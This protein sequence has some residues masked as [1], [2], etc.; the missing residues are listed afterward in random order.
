MNVGLIGLGK[1]GLLHAGILNSLEN[2]TLCA[3]SEKENML[4]KRFWGDRCLKKHKRRET[5]DF[6]FKSP[7]FQ[8]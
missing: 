8:N 6:A 7:R 2:V 1:M 4:L 3:I 5:V